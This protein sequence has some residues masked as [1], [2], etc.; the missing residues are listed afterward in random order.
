MHVGDSNNITV[1]CLCISVSAARTLSKKDEG[2]LARIDP[3]TTSASMHA[4]TSMFGFFT[5]YFVT[6][7]LIG[8]IL[9]R[10]D[11]PCFVRPLTSHNSELSHAF[12]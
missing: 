6:E 2:G 12:G 7:C 4:A 1:V 10:L 8:Q 3:L 9:L 5:P 11:N